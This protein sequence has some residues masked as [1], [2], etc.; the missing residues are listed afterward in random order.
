[1]VG[2]YRNRRAS[3]APPQNGHKF[4]IPR[5]DLPISV[6]LELRNAR[7]RGG[8]KRSLHQQDIEIEKRRS[9]IPARLAEYGSKPQQSR[10][11]L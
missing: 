4:A 5:R 8:V 11:L 3:G 10:Q 1:M 9:A 6:V 7:R 2:H